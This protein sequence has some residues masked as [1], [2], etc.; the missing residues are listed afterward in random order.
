MSGEGTD[1][2]TGSAQMI[3]HPF[4]RKS[5]TRQPQPDIAKFVADIYGWSYLPSSIASQQQTPTQTT[6]ASTQGRIPSV[7][8]APLAAAALTAVTGGSQRQSSTPMG[9]RLV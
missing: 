3:S 9:F 1:Q 7:R 8:S 6:A 4:I 2:T 5:E